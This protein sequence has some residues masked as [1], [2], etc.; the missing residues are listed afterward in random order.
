MTGFIY[1]ITNDINGKQYVGKTT[2]TLV[3]RFNDHC[4]DSVLT[5]CK[6]RPLYHAM[7]KY[8]K[9]H[10]HISQLEECELEILPEREQYW[11]ATLDTYH[12]GYNATLG[13]EGK[14]YYDYSLFINDFNI[15]MN[16]K[17]I[18]EKY[19]CNPET[20]SKAL[21]KAG[22]DTFRGSKANARFNRI[23]VLQYSMNDEFLQEFESYWAAAEWIITNKYTTVPNQDTVR[24]NISAAAK[25]KGYRKSAYGFKWK[26][27]E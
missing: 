19:N 25:L 2:D 15:G 10:F 26:L 11:I 8:G 12:N 6:G 20:V 7:N 5:H 18:A 9:E 4:K 22:L 13:G 3:R 16:I 24:K 14:Q 21:H 27:K 17:S 1:V 23:P